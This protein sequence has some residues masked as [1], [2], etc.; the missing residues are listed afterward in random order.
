MSSDAV[1]VQIQADISDLSQKLDEV[2]EKL[3]DSLGEKTEEIGDNIGKM[4]EHI[5]SGIA[6]FG[7]AVGVTLV[8]EKFNELK[9]IMDE[10]SEKFEHLAQQSEFYEVSTDMLQNI[11]TAAAEVGK[12]ST[13]ADIGLRTLQMRL[14]SA[15][16]GSESARFAFEDVGLSLEEIL[17]PTFNVYDALEA[18]AKS[19]R[20]TDSMF[21]LLGRS[22]A[23]FGPIL[24]KMRAGQTALNAATAEYGGLSKEQIDSLVAYHEESSKL[25][26]TI[27]NFTGRMAAEFAPTMVSA[28]QLFKEFGDIFVS[29]WENFNVFKGIQMLIDSFMDLDRLVGD[30][31]ESVVRFSAKLIGIKLPANEAVAAL[32]PLQKGMHE[33]FKSGQDVANRD[34]A[35]DAMTKKTKEQLKVELDLVGQQLALA[36]N[37]SQEKLDLAIEYSKKNAELYET[38]QAKLMEGYRKVIDASKE[39]YQEQTSLAEASSQNLREIQDRSFEE[40]KK[41]LDNAKS[42]GQLDNDQYLAAEIQMIKAKQTIDDAAYARKRNLDAG[43]VKAVIDDNAK[44]IETDE[45]AA[46][47]EIAVAEK[48]AEAKKKLK[49]E[50][51]RSTGKSLDSSYGEAQKN[52]DAEIERKQISDE[53]WLQMS[54]NLARAQEL[55][56]SQ[57]YDSL[58]AAAQGN[59]EKLR[60][61]D[62]QRLAAIQKLNQQ[63]ETYTNT[64]AKRT[65][66]EWQQITR[67]M[68]QAFETALQGMISGTM[69][70]QKAFKTM[71]DTMVKDIFSKS[72]NT[73]LENYINNQQQ[74]VAIFQIYDRV[75]QSLMRTSATQGLAI[76]GAE[77]KAG[78]QTDSAK[79]ASGAAAQVSSFLGP[80]GA[81]AAM[82]LMEAAVL[83]LIGKVASAEGGMMVDRDQL[84]MVHEDEMI[85][86]RQISKGIQERIIDNPS[87]GGT[88]S[89]GDT[90]YHFGPSMDAKSFERFVTSQSSRNA[91]SRAMNTARSRGTRNQR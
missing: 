45:K 19:G 85:L 38:D 80:V 74:Q 21:H 62:A 27:S 3:Q 67:P 82:A 72:L 18:M 66:Q 9:E 86:P 40:A 89:G 36:K 12:S 20:S 64:S 39:H 78:I 57:M 7:E 16:E 47:D 37:G 90:H 11:Y 15:R 70:F 34:D 6:E 83:A 25:S 30:A 29:V 87:G 35:L 43:N 26:L 76:Q 42:N 63:I 14:E 24:E 73:M 59:E 69:T 65:L 68:E 52:L 60:Q 53:T 77:T 56:T 22:T 2:S 88:G 32:T 31:G 55:T 91:I 75:K 49:E 10:V 28:M 79:A 58:D 4:F 23:A 41:L 46:S 48:V 5:M 61:N 50:E 33:L 17:K 44:I 54:I 13:V 84:A 8:Y 1:I 81:I 71:M 51:T